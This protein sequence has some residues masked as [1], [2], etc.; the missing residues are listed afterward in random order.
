MV[1]STQVQ[2]DM[3]RDLNF[4]STDL[5]VIDMTYLFAYS[6]GNFVSGHLGDRFP[7]KRVVTGGMLLAGSTYFIAV[8][9]GIVHVTLLLPFVGLWCLNGLF[10]STV[11]ASTVSLMNHW[12]PETSRGAIIGSWS[13]APCYGDI[14]GSLGA[15]L[16]LSLGVR[17]PLVVLPAGGLLC[18][19]ALLFYAVADE[20]PSDSL[21]EV[22]PSPEKTE[23]KRPISFLEA[24]TLPG[25]AL[26]AA[27]FAFVKLLNYGMMFWLPY[28]LS[29]HLGVDGMLRGFIAAS[30]DLGS[31]VGSALTGWFSDRLRS[32]VLVLLPMLLLGIPLFYCFRLGTRDT[33]WVYFVL[34]PLT[35]WAVSA[36]ANILSGAVA[37]DLTKKCEDGLAEESTA[38]IAGIIDG[39]GSL[40]AGLGQ[41]FIGYLRTQSWDAVFGF[42]MGVGG[43]AVLLLL[44]YFVRDVR[45][46]FS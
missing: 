23:E 14:F 25:V 45:S 46:K 22:V 4:S 43:C 36:S 12:F 8:L 11:W 28:Y 34:V 20:R 19:I 30:Y 31:I 39:T 27:D 1:K 6:V 13:A 41:I 42:L 17:W 40:G 5:G 16:L 2:P 18:C 38:T 3:S 32:R 35:G 37:A 9:L 7:I 44:P 29:T 24:W 10:Q 33:V 21:L 15:G 26:F